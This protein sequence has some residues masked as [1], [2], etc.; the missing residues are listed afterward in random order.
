MLKDILYKKNVHILLANSGH[1]EFLVNNGGKLLP[2][3][4]MLSILRLTPPELRV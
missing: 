4:H 3:S 1:H 2:N